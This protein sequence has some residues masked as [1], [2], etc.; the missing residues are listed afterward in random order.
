M[1]WNAILFSSPVS[2]SNLALIIVIFPKAYF[3]GRTILKLI[4]WRRKVKRYL[5]ILFFGIPITSTKYTH[6]CVVFYV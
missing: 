2:K 6:I 5:G 1:A 4:S 3:V